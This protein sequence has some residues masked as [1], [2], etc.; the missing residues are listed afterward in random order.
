MIPSKKYNFIVIDDSNLDCFIAEK[1]V[2]GTGKCE[3][4]RSFQQAEAALEWIAQNTIEDNYPTIVLVDIQMPVMDGFE[5]VE[6][7]EK[8][9][10]NIISQYYIYIISS[11]INFEDLSKVHRYHTV[12]EFLNK[13]LSSNN[14]SLLLSKDLF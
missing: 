11:S 12:K 13:P 6:A 3:S 5:F 7:F 2:K 10:F 1:I 8:L 9:P 4:V 14:L